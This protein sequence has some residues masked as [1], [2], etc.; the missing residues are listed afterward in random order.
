MNINYRNTVHTKNKSGTK[1]LAGDSTRGLG[2][3]Q[4][5]NDSLCIR[6]GRKEKLLP[7]GKGSKLSLHSYKFWATAEVELNTIQQ[8]QLLPQQRL[9]FT[10]VSVVLLVVCNTSC[11]NSVMVPISTSRNHWRFTCRN[12]TPPARRE[13]LLIYLKILARHYRNEIEKV[14][15]S[16]LLIWIMLKQMSQQFW[17][18]WALNS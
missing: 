4:F 16:Y 1:I 2:C 3:W 5:L 6:K 9:Q 7:R 8:F 13:N 17:V 12:I 18:L 14:S 15:G 10:Q 11:S